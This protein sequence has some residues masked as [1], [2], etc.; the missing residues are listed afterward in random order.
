MPH[1]KPL[2][3]LTLKE[4]HIKRQHLDAEYDRLDSQGRYVEQQEVLRELVDVDNELERRIIA[5]HE[6]L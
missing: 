3:Q 4:L 1:N 6:Q 2:N 5:E